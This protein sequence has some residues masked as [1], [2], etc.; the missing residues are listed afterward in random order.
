MFGES[1]YTFALTRGDMP[2]SGFKTDVSQCKG[3]CTL[4]ACSASAFL[5][6]TDGRTDRKRKIETPQK[7]KMPR[8]PDPAGSFHPHSKSFPFHKQS[9]TPKFSRAFG[10]IYQ[11]LPSETH[12]SGF[13]ARW[14]FF[15]II[16]AYFP[17]EPSI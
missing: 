4:K 16:F 3:V 1:G 5:W 6:R 12:N 15:G 8:L 11:N 14:I 9:Q 2:T 13:F 17:L 10:A 7:R